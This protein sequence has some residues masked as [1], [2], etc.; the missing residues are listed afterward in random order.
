MRSEQ[1]LTI[2]AQ[3]FVVTVSML[4]LTTKNAVW[5]LLLH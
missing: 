5:N 3:K 2:I 4:T 1:L